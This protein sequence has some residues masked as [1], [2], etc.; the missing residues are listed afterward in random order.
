[1]N[2]Q[3][4]KERHSVRLVAVPSHQFPAFAGLLWNHNCEFAHCGLSEV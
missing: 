3:Q 4:Q 1:M 2:F